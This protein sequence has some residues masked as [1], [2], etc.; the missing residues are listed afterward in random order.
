MNYVSGSIVISV[1]FF[2]AGSYDKF[3]VNNLIFSFQ[4]IVDIFPFNGSRIYSPNLKVVPLPSPRHINW[5]SELQRET[6]KTK[7]Q[8]E[9]V[10]IIQL[11]KYLNVHNKNAQLFAYFIVA[12]LV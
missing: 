9:K 4:Q 2:L 12:P 1:F 3:S 6:S 5:L 8:K 7:K 10:W 11:F